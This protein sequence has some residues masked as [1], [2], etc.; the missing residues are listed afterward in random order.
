MVKLGMVYYCFTI[1]T[2]FYQPA[3]F[4]LF[5]FSVVIM[6]GDAK[7]HVLVAGFNYTLICSALPMWNCFSQ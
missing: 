6:M 4:G 2:I 3:G 1:I 7:T 5:K